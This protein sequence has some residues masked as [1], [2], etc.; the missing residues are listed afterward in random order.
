VAFAHDMPE[1]TLMDLTIT[2][3]DGTHL[4]ADAGRPA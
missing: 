4:L 1:G 2:G 3:H